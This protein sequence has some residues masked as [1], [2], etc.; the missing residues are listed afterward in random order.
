MPNFLCSCGESIS[1]TP[2]PNPLEWLLINA[3]RLDEFESNLTLSDLYPRMTSMLRC[4][5]CDRLY[6][7]WNSEDAE[8][9]EYA[10]VPEPE[11][12]KLQELMDRLNRP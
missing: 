9:T 8:P 11:K 4:P 5:K 1:L 10:P 2:I 12:T 3:V 7:Y 6:I